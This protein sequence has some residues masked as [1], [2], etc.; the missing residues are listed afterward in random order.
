MPIYN[1]IFCSYRLEKEKEDK[2]IKFLEE[3]GYIIY[4]KKTNNK[5]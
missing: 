1:E 2:A 4:N 3:K 5:I